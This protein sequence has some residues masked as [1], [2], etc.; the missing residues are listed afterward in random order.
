MMT[1]QIRQS[2]ARGACGAALLAGMAQA[3]SRTAAPTTPATPAPDRTFANLQFRNI[4]PANMSGRIADVEGVPGN[5]GIVYL[6]SASGGV[7]KTVNGGTT[8]TPIF[9]S[10]PVQSIGD[11]ALEPGNPEVIYVG[12]GEANVRNSVSYGKGMYKSTDGGKTWSWLG[13]GDT[14]H[15]ARVVI[16]PRDV[17]KVYAAAIGHAYGPNAERGVFMSPDGGATWNKTLYIDDRHGASDLDIDPQNPNVLYAG[18][19]YFDRKQWTHRSGD[20]LGGVFKSVDGGK[21]W[22]KLTAGLPKLMGRIGIKVAPGQPNVVYALAETQQGY[23][24]RSADYGES[25]TKVS[26]DPNVLGRG[27]YYADLRVDPQNENRVYSI[28]MQLSVSIDGG[29]TFSRVPGNTHGDYQSLWIDP[30]NPRRIWQG[31]DGGSAVSYDQGQN[32]ETIQTFPIGQFYQLSYDMQEPHYSLFGGLQDN[33]VWRGPSRNR[34]LA[35]IL[36][37]HWELIQNGD[38]YYAVSHPDDPDLFLSDFQ[39]G[40]IQATNMRTRDVTEASPQPR[41]MDGYAVDSLKVRFNWNAPIVQSPHDKRVVYFA[42]SVV[43]RSTDWGKSWQAISPDISTNNKAR[44]GDAGGPVLKENTTAEYYANALSFAESAAQKGVLWVG[45]DDGLV[46]VSTDDGKSWTNVTR[47]IP[48]AADGAVTGIE[49]SRTEAGTAWVAIERHMMD[50]FAPYL[51][52]TTDFGKSW[53]NVAGNLPKDDYLHVVRQDPKNPNLI[54]VGSELGLFASWT[55][56]GTFSPLHLG[57]LPKVA[58]HE[59]LVH[60]RENDLIVATHGRSIFILDDAA[61][62]QGMSSAIAAKPMHL[63]AP[64]ATYRFAMKGNRGNIGEK[65]WRGA[66]PTYGAPLTWWIGAGVSDTIGRIEI[67][68]DGKAIRTMRTVAVKGGMN[69][70]IWD[71]RM[72]SPSLPPSVPTRN[73]EFQPQLR[74]P[75]V[76][77]GM[78]VAR[79]TVGGQSME[80]PLEVKGDPQSKIPREQLV[81]QQAEAIKLRDMAVQL[82]DGLQNLQGFQGQLDERR[83]TGQAL[84]GAE[85]AQLSRA[86]Q[87]EIVKFDSVRTQVTRPPNVPFY[88]EG[89]RPVERVMRLMNDVDSGNKGP[90]ASQLTYAGELRGEVEFVITMI[91]RQIQSTMSTINPMLEKLDLPKLV[92]PTRKTSAVME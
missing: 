68:Q 65:P 21:S 82:I 11:L 59:V 14:R 70:M 88:S 55:G 84:R 40:A 6:G 38:G 78:Y 47:A 66:N 13:L 43:Y 33:G 77:P 41:R 86:I 12:S 8:W 31:Q 16:N 51:F 56:G 85:A 24:F 22:K 3:Q 27:F 63:F 89:P 46:H 15:I 76:L 25:W 62:V 44:L 45:T 10:Q 17:Q 30:L 57:N 71:L 32:W 53:T 19:W 73:S 64:R 36:N 20:T 5:P 91:E 49:P 2:L 35:G 74:G 23:L 79:L 9:D 37:D 60:P 81:A 54:Y 1:N 48:I 69:R 90:V 72:D 34:E 80:Q 58:V 61:A 28:G 83:R 39:G 52:K 29:R 18:M 26:D 67:L 87:G 75:Q 92:A 42:G 7:W 50:D 4:G